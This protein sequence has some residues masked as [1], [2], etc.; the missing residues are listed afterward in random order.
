MDKLSDVSQQGRG[1]IDKAADAVQSGI[2]RGSA[3]A[4][5]GVEAAREQAKSALGK[6]S[7]RGGAAIQQVRDT[8]AQASDS[9]IEYTRANPVKALMMAAASGAL[10]I[11]VLKALSPS[12][13]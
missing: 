2:D 6:M 9:I 12:R 11:T 1:A 5:D 10:L 8:T 3:I 7:D 13:D 4:S